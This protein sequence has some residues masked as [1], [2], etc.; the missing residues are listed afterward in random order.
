MVSR[1]KNLDVATVFWKCDAIFWKSCG[2]PW[3]QLE[4]GPTL[5]NS[6]FWERDFFGTGPPDLCG[7]CPRISR[8]VPN[9]PKLRCS[10][11]GN[12]WDRVRRIQAANP[13]PPSIIATNPDEARPKI[14]TAGFVKT[15]WGFCGYPR[16]SRQASVKVGPQLK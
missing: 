7:V 16:N 6:E 14:P 4:L 11:P 9:I 12:F 13:K 15:W 10:G 1:N 2:V 5:I 8:Q 3:P